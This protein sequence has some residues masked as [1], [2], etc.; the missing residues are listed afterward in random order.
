LVDELSGMSDGYV[1]ESYADFGAGLIGHT[2]AILG[3]RLAVLSR[4]SPSN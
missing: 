3:R 4:L 2:A 1:D